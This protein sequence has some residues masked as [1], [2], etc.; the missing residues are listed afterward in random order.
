M[1]LA[2]NEALLHHPKKNKEI[3][4]LKEILGVFE[5]FLGFQLL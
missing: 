3:L 4:N 5:L 2:K 1:F